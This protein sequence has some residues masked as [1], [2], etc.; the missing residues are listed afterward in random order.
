[1]LHAITCFLGSFLLFYLEP[2][3]GKAFTL[4]LGSGARIWMTCMVF[5]QAVLLGGYLWAFALSRQ[6][7]RRRLLHAVLLGAAFLVLLCQIPGGLPFLPDWGQPLQGAS[8]ALGLLRHLAISAGLP[9]VALSATAPLVQAWYAAERPG[10]S[11]YRLYAASNLGSLAGLL[12]Y[13]FLVERLM[14]FHAQ[15]FLALAVFACFAGLVV[16]LGL[17]VPAENPGARPA[18]EALHPGTALKVV[19]ASAAGVMLLMGTTNHLVLNTA[20]VP[21]VW[22]GP[23]ALYL[24]TFIL[25]FE[26]RP[27]W[28][29]SRA[30]FLWLALFVASALLVRYAVSGAWSW[31]ILAGTHGL[32]FFGGLLCHA[33]LHRLKPAAGALP[34]YYLMLALG[35]VLGGLFM[36]LAAPLL[37]NRPSEFGASLLLATALGITLVNKAPAPWRRLAWIP[38]TASMAASAWIILWQAAA[39]GIFIR[40]YYGVLRILDLPGLRVLAN[41]M[42]IHGAVDLEHPR[43]PLAYYTPGSGVARTLEV[44][45]D[46]KPHLRV[47]VVGMGIGT[48]GLYDRPGDA[49]TFYEIS[50]AVVRIAAPGN[51]YFPILRGMPD[52]PEILLGDGRPLL[53]EERRQGHLRAF[54][55]LVIDA[56]SGDTVPWHLLTREAL[57]LYLAHLA[58]EGVLAFHISNPLP[59]ERVLL[60]HAR[61][62][63]LF[64]AVH[65]VVPPAGTGPADPRAMGAMYLLL[66]RQPDAIRDPRIM[67]GAVLGFGPKIFGGHHPDSSRV[68]PLSSDRPWTD[69]RSALADL[70][71]HRSAFVP[72]N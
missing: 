54:D 48:L 68:L 18:I 10:T 5:F 70:I 65:I 35:G 33:R 38:A 8:G 39:P 14:G 27:F 24:L 30:A 25:I 56:F 50:P 37:L 67:Q 36:G 29:D 41:G 71:L 57:D 55:L 61:S 7:G 58:P 64:G 2:M 20:A 26:G 6:R 15:A 12:A 22:V 3:L 63:N 51:P 1:M 32:V 72:G 28:E 31:Q 34:A 44:L 62:L 49:W 59:L 17:R 43:T 45:R 46:R 60:A 52:R 69:E 11:P 13:P 53:E 16:F 4:R 47:G 19:I 66:A 23:L 40:D 21:L 9:M 42:T